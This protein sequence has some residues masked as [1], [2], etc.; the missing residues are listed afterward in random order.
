MVPSERA[1]NSDLHRI[2]RLRSSTTTCLWVTIVAASRRQVFWV[3]LSYR[4]AAYSALT[5]SAK[6]W[7]SSPLAS[8]TTSTGVTRSSGGTDLIFY[9]Q[10]TL[11]PGIVRGFLYS[12]CWNCRSCGCRSWVNRVVSAMS[13]VSP[14]YPHE[15]TSSVRPTT[16]EKCCHNPTCSQ[17]HRHRDHHAV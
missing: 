15:P 17:V 9:L 10:K 11:S 12:P 1:S 7:T 3:P 6:M 2:G 5:L 4:S 13:A 8:T 16:S 14:L